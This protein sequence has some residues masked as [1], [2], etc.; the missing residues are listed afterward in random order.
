MGATTA[1]VDDAAADDATTPDDAPA[2]GGEVDGGRGDG[3]KRS[4]FGQPCTVGDDA[5]CID[6]LFCLVG[7]SGGAV[8]FCT[9]TCPKASGAA[10]PG[11]P[12]GMAAYC[13]VTDVNSQGDKGCA[14]VC[15]QGSQTYSCPGELQCQTTQEPAGSGQYLCLP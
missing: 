12:A 7:P 4:D 13:V 15:R 3:S 2:D 1:P 11:A 9:K 10:C 14:F 6:G 5:T 8:G